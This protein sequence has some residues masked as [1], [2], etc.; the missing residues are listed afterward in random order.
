M[1][2]IS[3]PILLMVGSVLMLPRTIAGYVVLRDLKSLLVM[4]MNVVS[5]VLLI[6]FL[7]ME[8]TQ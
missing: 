6:V 7:M 2:M 3:I 8:T 4:I 1:I 5:T